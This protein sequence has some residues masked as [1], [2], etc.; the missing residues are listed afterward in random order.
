MEPSGV[1]LTTLAPPLR[2]DQAL[3]FLERSEVVVH[4]DH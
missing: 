3:S 1:T 4:V 2:F